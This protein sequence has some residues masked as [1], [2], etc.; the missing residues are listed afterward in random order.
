MTHPMQTAANILNS[1]GI[2]YN[3]PN[4]VQQTQNALNSLMNMTQSG[5]NALQNFAKNTLSGTKNAAQAMANLSKNLLSTG[6]ANALN[7]GKAAQN[8][9]AA[10]AQNIGQVVSSVVTAS[11]RPVKQVLV[12]VQNTTQGLVMKG[13]V[14]INDAN[15]AHWIQVL[16]NNT[17]AVANNLTQYATDYWKAV[18]PKI[19]K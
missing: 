17:Q 19:G 9:T 2:K 14:L 11:I 6:L 10:A 15:P 13:L 18:L 4:P 7:L 1:M 12:F 3:L 8:L 16:F 5:A